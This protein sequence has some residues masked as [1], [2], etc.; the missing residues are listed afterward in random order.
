MTRALMVVALVGGVA[1]ADV[2]Q[3]QAIL[4]RP[5]TLPAGEAEAIAALVY[6]RASPDPLIDDTAAVQ[7]GAGYGLTRA[8][9]LT[10]LYPLQLRPDLSG[11]TSASAELGV[12]FLRGRLS[13]A[14]HVHGGW[15]HGT[16]PVAPLELGVDAQWRI[17]PRVALFTGDRELSI[18]LT[19][20]TKPIAIALPVGVAVQATPS[21]YAQLSTRLFTIGV[22]DRDSDLIGRDGVPLSLRAF[23]S[24]SNAFDVFA[25]AVLMDAVHPRDAFA[26]ALG[27]RLFF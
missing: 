20:D 12:T 9:D 23:V 1:H 21:V 2:A 6:T 27:V 18:G 19:G 3:P 15:Q 24:P 8:I 11:D 13:A 22:K 26:L 5:R 10:I 17:A 7:L 25:A 4:D 14:A 16:A